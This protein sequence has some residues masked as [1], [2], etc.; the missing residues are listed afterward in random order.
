MA[1]LGINI[2]QIALI[3]LR[4]KRTEPDPVQAAVFVEMAGADGIVCPVRPEFQLLTE[5]DVR[6]LKDLVKTHFNLQIPPSKNMLTFT[7]TV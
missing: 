3:R 7:H 5:R 1:R 2:E 4:E 6:L